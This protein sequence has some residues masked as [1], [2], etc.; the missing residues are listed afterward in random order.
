MNNVPTA[1]AIYCRLSLDK[2]DDQKAVRRQEDECRALAGRKGWP[3]VEVYVDNDISASDPRKKRPQYDRMLADIKAGKIDAIICW[4]TDRL[5]RQPR[6]LEEIIDIADKHGTAL[7]TVQGDIDLGTPNGRMVA[8]MLGA[9]ARQEVEQKSERQKAK[10]RQLVKEGRPR[11]GGGRAFGFE[12]DGIT[13][14]PH[15]AE[16]IRWATRHVIEGGSLASIIKKWN[17]EELRT[18]RGRS[19]GYPSLTALLTRWKNAGIVQ[20]DKKPVE[21]VEA[22]WKEIVDRDALLAVRAILSDPARRTNKDTARKHMLS[23]IIT[24]GKCGTRMRWGRMTTRAGVDY[25]LYVCRNNDP[26]CRVSILKDVAEEA[27]IERVASV[28]GTSG[29]RFY[30]SA[31]GDARKVADLRRRRAELRARVDKIKS[32]DIEEGDKLEMLA[33][34]KAERVELDEQIT[35]LTERDVLTALLLDLALSVDYS[36]SVAKVRE[37]F[38]AMDLDRRRMVIRS[39]TTIS[40]APARKGVRP[41]RALARER[42]KMRTLVFGTD[43]L[44]PDDPFA[45]PDELYREAVD[46]GEKMP[47]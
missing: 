41:T 40:V 18:A 29:L 10:N 11:V 34:R 22:V 23:G 25:E 26:T 33:A 45:D 42:I 35:R 36:E 43:R 46:R 4:H 24:C 47:I 27:V 19:W 20:H 15:E 37:R 38:E 7:A 6:Q 21:G 14:V 28:L 8:R 30:V 3:V 9:A 31:G 16:A 32:A 2:N 39:T 12:P 1:A 44:D 17:A 5:T 13:H